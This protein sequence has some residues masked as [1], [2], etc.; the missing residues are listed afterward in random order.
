MVFRWR[1]R[2]RPALYSRI[3]YFLQ[4][5]VAICDTLTRARLDIPVLACFRNARLRGVYIGN[6][7]FQY[8]L[9]E[10]R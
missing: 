4:V 8:L 2:T 7:P 9:L 1:V 3:Q 6:Y 5:V 10:C